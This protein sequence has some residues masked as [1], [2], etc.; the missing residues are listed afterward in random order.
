[1][2]WVAA[3][4]GGSAVLGGFMSNRAS[5]QQRD[6]AGRA[7]EAQMQMFNQ[8]RQ[9]LMPWQQAGTMALGDLQRRMG[10]SGDPNSP[11][12]GQL[13]HQFGLQDFQESPAY[14]FNLQ[15][16]KMALDKASAARGKFYAPS[17][18]QDI[19]KFS[20]GMASNEYQNAFS[21]YQTN[22]GNIWNRLNSISS[23]GQNAAAHL[24]GFGTTV[25]GEIGNNITGSG[26]AQAAGTVGM[27]NAATG[28]V[29]NYLNYQ[30]LQQALARNQGSTVNTGGGG[31]LDV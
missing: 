2:S 11:G 12:Y 14:Q 10:L 13:T 5:Q 29:N 27:A 30:L 18:L 20:Q 31:P 26:N 23:G 19:A 6:A 9:D 21:N 3:A 28:G 15:Q 25:G 1:M 24:G 4:I 17:T 7:S 16:G 22:M 8:T